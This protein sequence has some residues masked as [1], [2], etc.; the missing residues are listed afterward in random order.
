VKRKVSKLPLLLVAAWAA[1]LVAFMVVRP[2]PREGKFWLMIGA[3][4][5]FGVSYMFVE[6][7]DSR[8]TQREVAIWY[9]RLKAV[10]DVR[11]YVDDGHLHEWLE[12]DER[13]R[14]IQELQR[15]PAGSRSLK[16]ALAIV[17]PELLD[18][19]AF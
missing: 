16:R 17:S 7:L 1:L 15:M 2:R 19:N 13:E 8:R 11:D 10:V 18:E 3:A 5:A 6:A 9:D 14:L 12:A 4:L